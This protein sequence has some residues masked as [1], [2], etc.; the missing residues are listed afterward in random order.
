MKLAGQPDLFS[1]HPGLSDEIN[2]NIIQSEIE[3]GVFLDHLPLGTELDLETENRHYRI[4]NRGQGYV[5][6]SG[7]PKFCP[8]PLKARVHGSTW[9]GSMLKLRFIGRGMRLEFAPVNG[10][11]ITTSRIVDIRS[12][13]GRG[14]SGLAGRQ[15]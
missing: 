4:L 15:K 5:S 10:K 12:A 1:A 8:K 3:G 14:R 7:H 13:H 2:H 9:G 6:I 11:V